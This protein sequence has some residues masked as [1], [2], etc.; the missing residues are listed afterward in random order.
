MKRRL[1][2]V[3]GSIVALTVLTACSGTG[4]MEVGPNRYRVTQEAYIAAA[5]AET[6]V[7]KQASE[8]CAQRGQRADVRIT[9][10]RSAS[11]WSYATASGDFSCVAK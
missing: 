11:G 4:V 9:D 8:Y 7:V 10:S 2:G 6:S 5:N 1:A 3:Y